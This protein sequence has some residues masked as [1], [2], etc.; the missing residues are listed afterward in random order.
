MKNLTDI[1][2]A[3]KD[4]GYQVKTRPLE[5]NIVGIRNSN[6]INQDQF[7]DTIAVF[8]YDDKGKLIGFVAP[9]TTDPSTYFLK[10][11]INE[12]GSAILKSGQYVGA[13]HIGTHK[14]KYKALTQ[15]KPVSVIRDN[16][17]DGLT[18]FANITETGLY[19]INI[20]KASKKG[21]TAF[22]DKD[23]AGCQVFRDEKDFNTMMEWANNSAI[24]YGNTFTYTL[25]DER[26]VIKRRNTI[27]VSLLLLYVGIQ[28]SYLLY[29][30][31]K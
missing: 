5:L 9:A 27:F 1:V 16:D 13:Y 7:D 20:H 23:S 14:G 8:Y 22:I 11:P 31:L 12:K 25:L 19:G 24:K 29:K 26:D 18:D 30:K 15:I 6:P 4:K 17:R 10:N 3:L 21:N 2:K 28:T